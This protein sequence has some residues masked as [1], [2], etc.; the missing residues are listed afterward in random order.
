MV[1]WL[2][3]LFL[4]LFLLNNIFAQ[5]IE[6]N[7]TGIQEQYEDGENLE[8]LP[9]QEN[10]YGADNEEQIP[11]RPDFYIGVNI[12]IGATASTMPS[13][14]EEFLLSYDS[15]LEDP[16]SYGGL[17]YQFFL[18]TMYFFTN[19]F[20]LKFEAGLI[21]FKAKQK[22]EMDYSSVFFEQIFQYI[23]LTIAPVFFTNQFRTFNIWIGPYIGFLAGEAKYKMVD[24]YVP[25]YY[26]GKIEN[27]NKLTVGFTIGFSWILKGSSNFYIPIYIEFKMS[28]TKSGLDIPWGIDQNHRLF[29][30]FLGFCLMYGR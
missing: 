5:N 22:K 15:S 20:G 17:G 14:Y 2:S 4:T 3:I 21:R 16:E 10:D 8:L 18:S 12:G 6:E 28:I 13:R 23:T 1:K 25:Y 27:A 11:P 19:T 24:D 7:Q 26:E 9:S 30:F 29:G